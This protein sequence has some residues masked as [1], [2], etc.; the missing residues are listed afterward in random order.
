M[1]DQRSH[2][3]PCREQWRRV[4]PVLTTR[5]SQI[6]AAPNSSPQP[7]LE[8][9]RGVFQSDRE[10]LSVWRKWGEVWFLLRSS[11]RHRVGTSAPPPGPH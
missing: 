10:T 5:E 7:Q 3:A 6:P 11:T 4:L 8:K 9:G 1:K 2:S